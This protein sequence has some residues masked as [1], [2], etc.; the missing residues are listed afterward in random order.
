[1]RV[2]RVTGRAQLHI[3]P[4]TYRFCATRDVPAEPTPLRLVGEKAA[5]GPVWTPEYTEKENLTWHA[6]G[7]LP[8][9]GKG[10]GGHR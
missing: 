1:M 3:D 6:S 8:T 9:L 7:G 4:R 2:D 10:G 5:P